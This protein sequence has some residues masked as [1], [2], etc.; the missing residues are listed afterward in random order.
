MDTDL[1]V[2]QRTIA[3][4][5]DVTLQCLANWLKR[6]PRRRIGQDEPAIPFPAPALTIDG[7]DFWDWPTVKDWAIKSGK[8]SA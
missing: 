8:A 2:R 5:L 7:V 3:R 1:L 6:N 4:R